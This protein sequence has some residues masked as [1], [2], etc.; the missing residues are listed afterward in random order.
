VKDIRARRNSCAAYAKAE[1]RGGFQ[2]A[3]TA[4]LVDFRP[5]VDRAYLA[6]AHALG[7][8]WPARTREQRRW[9]KVTPGRGA[10]IIRR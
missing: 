6:N 7:R 4:D 1:V 3:V 2:V 9:P 5:D 10:D 8:L